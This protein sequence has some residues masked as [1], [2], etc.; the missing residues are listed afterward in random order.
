MPFFAANKK[1]KLFSSPTKN[2]LGTSFIKDSPNN[3]LKIGMSQELAQ[4]AMS[5]NIVQQIK[6]S[7]LIKEVAASQEEGDFTKN[8]YEKDITNDKKNEWSN[9][10]A[11]HLWCIYKFDINVFM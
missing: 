8:L 4:N 9:I 10:I 7:D 6:P 3:T 5:L 1:K 11:F 2:S